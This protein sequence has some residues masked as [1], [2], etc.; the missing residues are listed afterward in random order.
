MIKLFFLLLCASA[1]ADVNVSYKKIENISNGKPKSLIPV[2]TNFVKLAKKNKKKTVSPY[3]PT[4]ILV[5]RLK[6]QDVAVLIKTIK[7][8]GKQDKGSKFVL[9]EFSR[10]LNHPYPSVREEVDRV[11]AGRGC[12]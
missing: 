9:K 11:P 8:I 3:V 1:L 10:L 4:R 5:D 2:I 6:T 7:Q 12:G